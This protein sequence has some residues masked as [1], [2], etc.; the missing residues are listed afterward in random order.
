[1]ASLNWIVDP[2]GNPVYFPNIKQEGFGVQSTAP[3][4]AADNTLTYDTDAGDRLIASWVTNPNSTSNLDFWKMYQ[5]LKGRAGVSETVWLDRLQSTI[6]AYVR[7]DGFETDFRGKLN[8]RREVT[9]T[10]WQ[11]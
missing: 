1:M 9:I 6:V 2:D 8:N 5:Y 3:S 7:V 4:R 11:K 10:I